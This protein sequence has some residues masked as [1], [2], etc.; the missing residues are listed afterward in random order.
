[1]SLPGHSH[2]DAVRL[3]GMMPMD[4]VDTLTP[5]SALADVMADNATLLRAL[6]MLDEPHA[7]SEAESGRNDPIHHLEHRIDLL[8]LMASTALRGMNAMPMERPC[9]L[10]A[11]RLHWGSEQAIGVGQRVWARIYLRHRIALPL[12]LPGQI[13]EEAV[14]GDLLWHSMDIEPLEESLQNDLE[15]FIFRHHRR[16]IARQRSTL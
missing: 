2:G 5:A 7:E 8:L 16:Q 4:W 14:S 10:S 3:E 1:M 13:V 11:H 12:M 6:L 9:V 15:R